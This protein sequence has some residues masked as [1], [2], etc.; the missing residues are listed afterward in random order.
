M[1]DGGPW[2]QGLIELLKNVNNHG[3]PVVAFVKSNTGHRTIST[4]SSVNHHHRKSTATG[5]LL[6]KAVAR[7]RQMAAARST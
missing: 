1:I 6:D 3:S 4:I 7:M 5:R 2:Q